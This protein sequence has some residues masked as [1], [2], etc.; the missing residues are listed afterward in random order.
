MDF[1]RY[2][3]VRKPCI[4]DLEKMAQHHVFLRAAL[5]LWKN[6]DLTLEQAL[7]YVVTDLVTQ[8]ERLMRESFKAE[9]RKPFNPVIITPE[10]P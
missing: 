8:S 4:A 9:L 6:G 1:P 7:I 5:Q 3:D 2:S 10:K